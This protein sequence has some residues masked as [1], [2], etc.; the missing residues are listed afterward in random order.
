MGPSPWGLKESDD[1]ATEQNNILNLYVYLC[2][3]I[4]IDIIFIYIHVIYPFLEI[5]EESGTFS[6]IAI[7]IYI[8]TNLSK[9][10]EIFIATYSK[11]IINVIYVRFSLWLFILLIIYKKR[12]SKEPE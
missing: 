4:W 2:V 10:L 3:D 12:K 9:G 7:R 5:V 8:D 1:L 6:Y 11:D